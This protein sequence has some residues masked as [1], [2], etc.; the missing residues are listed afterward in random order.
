MSRKFD[1]EDDLDILD[2]ARPFIRGILAFLAYLRR[3]TV[4]GC[5]EI[6]D[7]FLSKLE[8]DLKK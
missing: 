6:A 7:L 5:Y 3:D 4:E 8:E 2:Q 1:R